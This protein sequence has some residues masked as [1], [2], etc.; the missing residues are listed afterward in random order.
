[1]PYPCCCKPAPLQTN[2]PSCANPALSDILSPL[3]FEANIPEFKVYRRAGNNNP[4]QAFR[5]FAAT[6]AVFT[7][8]AF[9]LGESPPYTSCCFAMPATE[10]CFATLPFGRAHRL[11]F[12]GA[13]RLE[14]FTTGIYTPPNDQ[15]RVA[16][17]I[18]MHIDLVTT[19]DIFGNTVQLPPS[20]G[21]P[22]IIAPDDFFQ[23]AQLDDC[24]ELRDSAPTITV[25][26][27][28]LPLFGQSFTCGQYTSWAVTTPGGNVQIT[29]MDE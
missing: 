9:L 5:T 4:W 27:A 22:A 13:I 2:C 18:G 28:T 1:M 10:L 12:G 11:M 29:W 14:R 15:L 6:T 21:C 24:R 20:Y 7:N 19:R 26:A 25:Q 3:R 8:A 16:L 23:T 17:R